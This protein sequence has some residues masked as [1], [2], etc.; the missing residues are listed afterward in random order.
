MIILE[1]IKKTENKM[2]K[3]FLLVAALVAGLGMTAC[4]AS[5]ETSGDAESVEEV[6]EGLNDMKEEASDA[7]D[8]AVE[9]VKEEAAEE[10]EEMR[11]EAEHTVKEMAEDKAEEM[12]KDAKTR[13]EAETKA[14]LNS[15]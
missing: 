2:K 10:M 9:D 6:M 14:V 12:V 8:E 7:M 4:T 3:R 5:V 13:V 15:K 11:D 1:G